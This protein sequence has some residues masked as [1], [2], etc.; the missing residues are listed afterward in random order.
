VEFLGCPTLG[1][2]TQREEDGVVQGHDYIVTIR[3]RGGEVQG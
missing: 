2:W 1:I 3:I